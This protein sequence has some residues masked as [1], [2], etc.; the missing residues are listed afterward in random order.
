MFF[1]I[2]YHLSLFFFVFVCAG[3]GVR[4]MMLISSLIWIIYE[5]KIIR[6]TVPHYPKV[7]LL[8]PAYNEENTIVESITHAIN[9]EYPCLEIIVVNDGSKDNTL[10][11]L[12]DAFDLSENYNIIIDEVIPTQQVTKIFTSNVIDNLIIVDK[13]NGGKADALNCAI[14]ASSA[15]YIL[16]LD[17]DT[18][19]TKNTIQYLINPFLMNKKVV[20]TSGSV[21]IISEK[22]YSVFDDLQKIEFVNSISLF[23]TGWNFINSN[24]IISGA[25]GLFKRDVMITVGGYHNLAI[26]EDMEIIIRLHQNL[27]YNKEKYVILQL[28]YPTCFTNA[29]PGYRA[30]TNQRKRWQKGLLSS[31][32]LHINLL[33]NVK[34][35]SVGLI[36]MP[37]YLF[38]EVIAPFIELFGLGLY[39][40]LLFNINDVPVTPLLIWGI[41]LIFALLNNWLSISLDNFFLRDMSWKKYFRLLLSSCMDPFFYHFFQ[42]YCKIKG[43]I[44]YLTDIQISTVWDTKR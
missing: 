35:K 14:N 42:L 23:R 11:L 34:Y 37:F 3:I 33:F 4:F 10:E 36:G 21:R 2:T 39:I 44:E 40:F 20:A 7:S 41:G 12:I 18:I 43:T 15:D 6:Y 29:V 13:K 9:Q 5:K 8:I 32:R 28:A 17:A 31:L 19:L 22:K 25:L 16:C 24:L 38:F 30:M 1:Q 26:G 27:I